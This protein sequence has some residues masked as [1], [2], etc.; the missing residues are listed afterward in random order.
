[1]S[2]AYVIET[3]D[4]AAGIVISEGDRFRFYSSSRRFRS[5]EGSSYRRPRDAEKAVER[6]VFIASRSRHPS[7]ASSSVVIRRR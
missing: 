1:M 2:N 3:S 7:P 5:L 6:A 4:Q